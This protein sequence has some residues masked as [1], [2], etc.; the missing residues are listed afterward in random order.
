MKKRKPFLMP[1][2]PAPQSEGQKQRQEEI[3]KCQQ[4]I[5]ALLAQYRCTLVPDITFTPNGQGGIVAAYQV[6]VIG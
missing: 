5:N 3:A 4:G 1:P 2:A 6:R